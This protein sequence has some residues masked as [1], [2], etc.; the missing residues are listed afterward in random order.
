MNT[1]VCTDQVQQGAIKYGVTMSNSEHLK[2]FG[3]ELRRRRDEKDL[4]QTELGNKIGVSQAE[5]GHWERGFERAD[6]KKPKAPEEQELHALS[7]ALDWPMIEIQ[8][9]LGRVE[10]VDL[11]R[12]RDMQ[13]LDEAGYCDIDDYDKEEILS[14]IA[15]KR[16]KRLQQEKR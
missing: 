15:L 6:V 11:Q 3:Q 14:I 4:T 10:P 12:I 16:K 8:A 13:V 7:E 5:I 2:R 1:L 9:A